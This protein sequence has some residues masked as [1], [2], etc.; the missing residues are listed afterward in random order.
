MKSQLNTGENV[1][2]FYLQ[3]LETLSHTEKRQMSGQSG[4]EIH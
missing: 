2:I 1:N 4:Q 3:I